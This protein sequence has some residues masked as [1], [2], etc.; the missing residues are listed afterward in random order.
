MEEYIQDANLLILSSIESYEIDS[1]YSFRTYIT[2][3]IRNY[4]DSMLVNKNNNKTNK[5]N[6][7]Y[8][9]L[10]AIASQNALTII[11]G[12]LN[13]D[14]YKVAIRMFGFSNDN[15][16]LSIEHIANQLNKDEKEIETIR[17]KLLN[18]LASDEVKKQFKRNK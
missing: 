12:L 6:K 13:E 16:P 17:K 7:K 1:P 18:K 8:Q 15:I 5:V 10:D 14:E 4:F 3:Q 2:Y 11:E 9:A